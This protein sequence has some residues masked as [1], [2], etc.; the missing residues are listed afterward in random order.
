MK[1]S[2]PSFILATLFADAYA[3][4]AGGSVTAAT[5]VSSAVPHTV[6]AIVIRGF[7]PR[8]DDIEYKEAFALYETPGTASVPREALG[9]LLRAVGQN[10]M[11]SEVDNIVSAAS[12]QVNYDEFLRIVNRPGGFAHTGTKEEEVI[13]AFQAFDKDGNGKISVEELRYVMTNLG[14][15][16]SDAE[17]D[18]LLTRV[19]PDSDGNV[20]YD[21]FLATILSQ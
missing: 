19:R 6:S 20:S 13:R 9:D 14:K 10:P 21:S 5:P 18:E 7:A 3:M 2:I 8:A 15:K 17:V 4:P 16:L 11:Q 12:A 1:L